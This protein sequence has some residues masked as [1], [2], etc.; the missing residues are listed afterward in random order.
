MLLRWLVGMLV[1]SIGLIVY[2]DN[3]F[4]LKVL[5]GLFLILAA[6]FCFAGE[7]DSEEKLKECGKQ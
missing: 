2:W 7:V 5:F 3:L 6:I 1:L 4:M